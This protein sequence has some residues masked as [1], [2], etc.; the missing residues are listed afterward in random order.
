MTSARST[1][2]AVAS[3]FLCDAVPG[4]FSTAA[5]VAGS[6]KRENVIP[7]MP[8]TELTCNTGRKFICVYPWLGNVPC[9]ELTLFKYSSVTQNAGNESAAFDKSPRRM[10]LRKSRTATPKKQLGAAE[11]SSTRGIGIEIA[12]RK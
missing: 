9:G 6:R 4:R 3:L 8:V 5:I 10:N 11:K 1:P 2:A 12:V 7:H